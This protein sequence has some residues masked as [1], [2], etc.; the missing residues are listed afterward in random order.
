MT[1]VSVTR[2]L[3]QFY[4]WLRPNNFTHLD[5][6]LGISIMIWIKMR[7]EDG[8]T[9]T[10]SKWFYITTRYNLLPFGLWNFTS[11]NANFCLLSVLKQAYLGGRGSKNP[12]KRAYVICTW[13]VP[14]QLHT[15]LLYSTDTEFWIGE[16][17]NWL[18]DS[19]YY[20][21]E[22]HA[23]LHKQLITLQKFNIPISI[24]NSIKTH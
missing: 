16:F 5:S 14:Y 12:K 7:L 10:S 13:M 19:M 11:E 24:D 9:L 2:K 18:L 17:E 8:I 21:S 20:Y 3:R 1:Q 23:P 6:L 15:L 4:F 22:F